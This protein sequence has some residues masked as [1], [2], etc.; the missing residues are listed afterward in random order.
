MSNIRK[1]FK[2]RIDTHCYVSDK[3]KTNSKAN[4]VRKLIIVKK[5]MFK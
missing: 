4:F 3:L 5:L 1:A 2:T